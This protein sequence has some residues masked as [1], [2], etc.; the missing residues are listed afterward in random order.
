MTWREIKEEIL[1]CWPG[2]IF[3][4]LIFGLIGYA[5]FMAVL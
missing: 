4:G 5:I 1:W 2:K 3:L